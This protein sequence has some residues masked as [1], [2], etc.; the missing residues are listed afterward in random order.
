[1]GLP[2]PLVLLGAPFVVCFTYGALELV[3]VA[4]GPG[5]RLVE[6]RPPGVLDIDLVLLFSRYY[7]GSLGFSF[8]EPAD[9]LRRLS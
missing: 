4:G 3:L 1:M 6:P 2:P 8:R 5:T 9:T 7:L